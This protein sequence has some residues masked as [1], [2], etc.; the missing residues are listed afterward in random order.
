MLISKVKIIITLFLSC[1]LFIVISAAQQSAEQKRT[2][3]SE[4]VE[5]QEL[6][7]G[8]KWIQGSSESSQLTIVSENSVSILGGQR[9]NYWENAFTSPLLVYRL[10]GDFD[11]QVDVYTPE[12]AFAE[13]DF[14]VQSAG[15][16][17]RPVGEN[18]PFLR[19]NRELLFGNQQIDVTNDDFSILAQNDLTGFSV[20]LRIQRVG[21]LFTLSY[22]ESSADDWIALV[23]S[24]ERIMPS[25][26]EI[27]LHAYSNNVF[28]FVAEFSNVTFSEPEILSEMIPEPP[29]EDEAVETEVTG[30]ALDV[31]ETEPLVSVCAVTA[32]ARTNVRATAS[33]NEPVLRVL[34]ESKVVSAIAQA[35]DQSGRTWYNLADGGW[36]REDTVI[37]EDTCTDLPIV[38]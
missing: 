7:S 9:T 17:V 22:R 36:V 23:E 1:S 14:F 18:V 28:R 27:F 10:S 15:I 11:V 2:P 35:M 38:E 13:G 16:G 12:T 3:F 29:V 4:D 31:E 26:V 21:N 32:R 19:I 20:S 24:Q 6:T 8:W 34:D 33:V 5:S 25:D 30:E 37:V